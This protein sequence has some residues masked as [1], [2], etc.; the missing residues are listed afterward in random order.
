[1]SR[2]IA[3]QCSWPGY[4]E[5][6]PGMTVNV[7]VTA[8]SSGYRKYLIEGIH[9]IMGVEAFP[10]QDEQYEYTTYNYD[11]AYVVMRS[12]MSGGISGII[13]PQFDPITGEMIRDGTAVFDGAA[14]GNVL[15][16]LHGIQVEGNINAMSLTLSLTLSDEKNG[17]IPIGSPSYG[18]VDPTADTVL[19]WSLEE[20]GYSYTSPV[21]TG[22]VVTWKTGSGTEHTVSVSGTGQS[23]TLAA[24]SFAQGDILQWKV[25]VTADTGVVRETGWMTLNTED[26]TAVAVPISPVNEIVDVTSPVIFRWSHTTIYGTAQ[27]GAELQQSPDGESW[28]AL[29]TVTGPAQAYEAAD[30][31]TALNPGTGG[32]L[33][34]RVRT[35]NADG[36]FGPWSAPVQ[37]VVV[38]APRAPAVTVDPAVPMAVVRWNANGQE[39]YQVQVAGYDTGPMYGTD[40]A[41][42]VPEPLAD[43]SYVARVRVVNGFGLWSEWGQWQF[44]VENTPGNAITLT[45]STRT[46]ADGHQEAALRWSVQNLA[47]VAKADGSNRGISYDWTDRQTCVISGTADE[48]TTPSVRTITGGWAIQD[49]MKKGRRYR[50]RWSGCETE[51]VH[52]GFMLYR[53]TQTYLGTVWLDH[54]QTEGVLELP[55]RLNGYNV[56]GARLGLM[57]EGGVTVSDETVQVFEMTQ[58]YESYVVYRDGQRIAETAEQSLQDDLAGAGPHV[59]RVRGLMPAEGYYTDSNEVELE[60][61]L[62]MV[63]LLDAETGAVLSLPMALTDDLHTD[64]TRNRPVTLQHWNG[65]GLPSAEIGE[66]ERMS[67]QLRPSFPPGWFDLA[68][69]LERLIGRLVHYRDPYENA[70][71]GVLTAMGDEKT[72]KRRSYDL[73]IEAVDYDPAQRV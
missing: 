32:T 13:V 52:Y 71:W 39:G 42:P 64:V 18:H 5:I 27:T 26:G 10:Q 48:G 21:Q 58:V 59:Y 72:P 4:R 14:S 63:E 8:L 33:F 35:S 66:A 3:L 15:G 36:I 23:V 6:R 11:G 67:V 61:V 53:S 47:D 65:A 29:G 57:V 22:A 50:L 54:D 19:R 49:G 2:T 41:W 20:I 51:G 68:R 37:C 25:S 44:T 70:F 31:D 24:G 56:T 38:A 60:T 34:W 1:M 43:G 16:L 12:S 28:E 30:P 69:R 45:G 17:L 73:L 7:P 46:T 9:G 62:R 55:N 40:T